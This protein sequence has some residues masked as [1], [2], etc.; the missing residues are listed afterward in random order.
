M[1]VKSRNMAQGVVSRNDNLLGQP[2]KLTVQQERLGGFHDCVLYFCIFQ[3]VC[4]YSY[5]HI[6]QFSNKIMVSVLLQ[7]IPS[8]P[9]LS[10]CQYE[11]NAVFIVLSNKTKTQE[12]LI[13]QLILRFIL[14]IGNKKYHILCSWFLV[15]YG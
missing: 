14:C 8:G 11:S 6:K 7:K 9:H 12:T 2:K 15:L 13:N 4:N 3:D 5:Y 10:L 1:Q